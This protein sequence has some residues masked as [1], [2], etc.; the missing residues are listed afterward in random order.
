MNLHHFVLYTLLSFFYLLHLIMN[1][2]PLCAGDKETCFQ[3]RKDVRRFSKWMCGDRDLVRDETIANRVTVW[4][5]RRW[6][7]RT[8]VMGIMWTFTGVAA[9]TIA[10]AFS[11]FS[12]SVASIPPA[13]YTLCSLLGF[14]ALRQ[15]NMRGLADFDSS[16]FIYQEMQLILLLI[17]PTLS[18]VVV[19]GFDSSSNVT[20]WCIMAPAGSIFYCHH[21]KELVFDLESRWWH[22]RVIYKLQLVIR[23]FCPV[24][25]DTNVLCMTVAFVAISLTTIAIDPYVIAIDH[26][27]PVLRQV[28]HHTHTRFIES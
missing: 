5:R 11:S 23:E 25:A 12:L 17:L 8:A 3:P 6:R 26:P 15:K 21:P 22:I 2:Q 19:G 13:L 28:I 18:H 16:T 9:L 27:P 24:M 10:T 7:S 20:T 14:L 4:E 1:V